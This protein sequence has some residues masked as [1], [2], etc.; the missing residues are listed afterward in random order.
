M[1]LYVQGA[2]DR[3]AVD[4]EEENIFDGLDIVFDEDRLAREAR[5]AKAF[6]ET[7]FI[8]EEFGAWGDMC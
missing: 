1:E 7:C 4:P 3:K 6:R 2:L 8:W 5:E